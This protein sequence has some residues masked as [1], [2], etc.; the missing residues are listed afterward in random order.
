MEKEIAAKIVEQETAA[1]VASL[2]TEQSQ[3]LG[4]ALWQFF[5]KEAKKEMKEMKE[6]KETST[7]KDSRGDCIE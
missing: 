2:E 4:A 6:M 3:L 7:L 1:K 5:L